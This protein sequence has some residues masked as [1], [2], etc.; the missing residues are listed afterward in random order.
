MSTILTKD[1]AAT[2]RLMTASPAAPDLSLFDHSASEVSAYS[3]R[4]E[5]TTRTVAVTGGK[6]GVGKSNLVVNI[7]LELAAAGR[8]VTV[9]DADLALANADVLFGL[10]PKLHLG[11]V[12]SGRSP[13]NKV[14]LDVSERVRLIP[15]GSGVEELANLSRDEHTR[16]VAELRA[17]ETESDYLLVDTAAGIGGNVMGVLRAAAEIVVVTTPDPTAVVDAYATIKVLHHTAPHVPVWVVVNNVVGVGDADAVFAQLSSAATRFLGRDLRFLGSVPHDP[18]LAGAVH[19]QRPVV[20]HAP[21]A[22]SSRAFRLIGKHLDKNPPTRLRQSGAATHSFW[23]GVGA[24][25]R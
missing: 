2:L 1:Q 17:M 7:A 22:P 20:S 3:N 23:E 25:T 18:E 21:D 4:R 14:V 12:L 24:Q 19:R 13:L 9:F 5:H 11:H 6:G 15:G 16:L 8:R 10:N